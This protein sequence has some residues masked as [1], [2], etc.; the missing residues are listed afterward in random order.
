MKRL[1]W[2]LLLV[3]LGAAAQSFPS[4]PI[5]IVVPFPPGGASDAL[6]RLTAERLPAQLGQPAIVENRGGA[7]GNLGAELVAR[8]EPDGHT[9]LATPPHILT[10]NHLLYK[11]AFDPAK[12]VPVSIIA[13]YPN[14]LLAHPALKANTLEELISLARTRP[15]KINI[16]SQGN[17]TSSHLTAELF[18]AL[19]HIDLLHVPYKGTG[20]AMT[21]LLGGQV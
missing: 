5:R 16:A 20:P 15:G 9:L 4:K 10:I 18:K 11:L 19:A 2:A 14:V 8:A 1:L 17:G 3:S 21:D 7:G 12:F 6:V 13:A